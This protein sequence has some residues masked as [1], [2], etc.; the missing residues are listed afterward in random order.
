MLD[1]G[2][3]DQDRISFT[4]LKRD[5]SSAEPRI[6]IE[7]IIEKKK[8][9][10][11]NQVFV[12][13][14]AL[15][16]KTHKN[17][18]DHQ[19]IHPVSDPEALPPAHPTAPLVPRGSSRSE[20]GDPTKESVTQPPLLDTPRRKKRGSCCCRCVCYTLLV[21]FLLIVI[22]GAAVGI[23][24]LVFRP[25]L[26]DY[27]IDRL[28][29]TRFTF[30]QDSSLSTAFNVTITAKNPNE[31]IGIYYEDGS[32]I[33]VLYMQTRLSNGS[34]P[35]FYQGHENTTII[36]VE[37]TGYTRNAT[38]LMATLQEQQRLTE[39]IPLRIRVTQPVRIKL[40]KLKLMEVKFMVRCSVSVDSLAA[41]NVIRVRSSNCKFRFRL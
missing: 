8:K 14:L 29:L 35:K 20:H 24:Y 12:F 41:N 27:N 33:S 31:K 2:R 32:R 38:S 9:I 22:V 13:K 4:K 1:D 19:K 26:P 21:I 6:D 34:L 17:M 5:T 7:L 23:L 28:L 18:S 37:M 10:S 40:G 11:L 3:A 39:S 30:N 16:V 15:K 36:F 25:K